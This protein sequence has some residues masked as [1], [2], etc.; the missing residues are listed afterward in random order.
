MFE[1]KRRR[2]CVKRFGSL[3]VLDKIPVIIIVVSCTLRV[4]YIFEIVPQ[5]LFCSV[6]VLFVQLRFK[7][8]FRTILMYCLECCSLCVVQ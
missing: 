6:F 8:T 4:D 1:K 3:K 2:S 7:S 5:F